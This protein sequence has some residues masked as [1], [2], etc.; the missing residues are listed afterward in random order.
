MR[1]SWVQ[2]KVTYEEIKEI[3]FHK[4]HLKRV[5]FGT[6]LYIFFGC[7]QLAFATILRFPTS[8]ED[9][10][11]GLSSWTRLALSEIIYYFLTSRWYPYFEYNQC[12]LN[13]NIYVYLN[14]ARELAFNWSPCWKCANISAETQYLFAESKWQINPRLSDFMWGKSLSPSVEYYSSS[15][16]C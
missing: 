15:S 11:T 1:L 13:S 5:I 12:D 2:Y 9:D 3:I 6:F 8:W 4:I 16:V 14:P 7:F 10:R